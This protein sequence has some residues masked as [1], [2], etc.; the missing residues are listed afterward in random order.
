MKNLKEL[1]KHLVD[2]FSNLYDGGEAVQFL[3]D[4]GREHLAAKFD[5]DHPDGFAIK[6]GTLLIE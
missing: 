2:E 5:S 3:E 4:N 1:S 6:R